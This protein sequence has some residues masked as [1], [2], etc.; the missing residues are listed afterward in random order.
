MNRIQAFLAL[1][2]TLAPGG[3]SGEEH[4]ARPTEGVS[5]RFAWPERLEARVELRRVRREPGRRES[6]FSARFSTRAVREGE[7]VRIS[8]RGTSW[9]GDLPFP[10]GHAGRALRASE[11]VVEVVDARGRFAGLEG[12]EAMRPVLSGILEVAEVPVDQAGRAVEIALA[13]MRAET[14][15]LWNVQ[16]GFWIGADLTLGETYAMRGEAPVPFLPATRAGQEIRF[17]A[18]RRVP[19]AA[20]EKAARCV[21]LLLRATP[22]PGAVARAEAEAVAALGTAAGVDT[23][24][25][26]EVSAEAEA[27]VVVEPGTLVPHQLVWTKRLRVVW[28]TG[29]GLR[30][31]EREDRSE[32]AWRYAR[33]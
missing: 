1:A 32:Y 15:E 23:A 2:L 5:L 9:S 21:E 20:G 22:E 17:S 3:A 11:Q 26:R 14:E 28:G 30:S 27:L 29:E 31:A 6:T 12:L 8:A 25:V 18:R 13:A 4:P 33:R 7:S 16:A 19:C 24:E 10:E